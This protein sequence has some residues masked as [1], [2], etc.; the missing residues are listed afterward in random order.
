[1]VRRQQPSTTPTT[2]SPT[3][4]PAWS[5]V[6]PSSSSSTRPRTSRGTAVFSPYATDCLTA[7]A[8]LNRRTGYRPTAEDLIDLPLLHRLVAGETPLAAQPEDEE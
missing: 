5:T 6:C 2:R 8:Q 1:V 3:P 4:R 7:Q